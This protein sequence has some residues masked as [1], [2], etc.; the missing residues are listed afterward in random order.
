MSAS[1]ESSAAMDTSSDSNDDLPLS[2][3]YS[4]KT[5]TGSRVTSALG[6]SEMESGSED[7]LSLSELV[8]KKSKEK[9]KKSSTST[10]KSESEVGTPSSRRRRGSGESY[11]S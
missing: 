4:S 10:I 2:V 6:G 3:A 9:R 8:K 7:E 11:P 1:E 5:R